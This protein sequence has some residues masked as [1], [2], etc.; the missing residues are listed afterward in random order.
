[1]EYVFGQTKERQRRKIETKKTPRKRRK[2]KHC[3][4]DGAKRKK[5]EFF[6]GKDMA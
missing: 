2:K 3:K 5:K 1:M 6:L 4:L